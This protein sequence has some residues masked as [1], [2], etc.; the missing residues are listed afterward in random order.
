MSPI[1]AM[2]WNT[3][4]PHDLRRTFMTYAD[5]DLG[6]SFSTI[7]ALVNHESNSGTSSGSTDVTAGY[8]KVQ[9]PQRRVAMQRIAEYILN[10][11]GEKHTKTDD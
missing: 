9:M 8:I 4:T 1:S 2:N 7:K 10:K 3:I 5:D 6:I 11:S